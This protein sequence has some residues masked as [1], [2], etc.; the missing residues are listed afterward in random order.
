MLKIATPLYRALTC[1]LAVSGMRIEEAVTRKW[2]E[3]EI[4]T[5]WYARVTLRAGETK[6]RYLRYTFLTPE[7]VEWLQLIRTGTSGGRIEGHP[8]Y[9]I[10]NYD[11]STGHRPRKKRLRRRHHRGCK[12][13]GDQRDCST[14]NRPVSN[15]ALQ[16]QPSFALGVLVEAPSLTWFHEVRN[17]SVTFPNLMFLAFERLCLFAAFPELFAEHSSV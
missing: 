11:L 9:A 3:L 2:A 14:D 13:K 7:S 1:L 15:L 16:S 8:T 10:A 17:E 5:P 6:A 4:R 12:H